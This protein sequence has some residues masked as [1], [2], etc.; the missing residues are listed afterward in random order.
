MSDT[1][2]VSIFDVLGWG[3]EKSGAQLVG[4]C[5]FCGKKKLYAN[6]LTSK[7]DCKACAE[8]G[9][10]VTA[11]SKMHELVW[12]PAFTDSVAEALGRFRG[13][14]VDAFQLSPLLGYDEDNS[15]YTW[16]VLKPNGMPTTVRHFKLPKAGKKSAVMALKGLPLGLLGAELLADDDRK[17]EP[18]YITEGEWDW[19][20]WQWALTVGD[21]PGIVVSLPGANVLS[22]D[23][24]GW[25]AGRDVIG[26]YDCD[27]AGRK[28]SVRAYEKL[29]ST[30]KTLKFLHWPR[31]DKQE[32]DGKRDGYDIHDL[33]KQY[34]DNPIVALDYVAS[35][36]KLTPTGQGE[37]PNA[38]VQSD[39]RRAA[40]EELEPI[41]VDELHKAFG[42]WLLLEN[43]DLV[44][45]TMAVLWTLHLPGNPLWMF[46]IAPPSGSKSETIMPA[47]AWWRV[48]A[49]SNMTSKSLVSGF[50]GP[51]GS[52]PSLLAALDGERACLAIKD[53]TPLL[54]GRPEERDEVFGILR[55]A[56]DGSV[57]KVF[58]NG[59][60]RDYKK[61]HFTVMAGVTPAIDAMS[62]I[63]MGERFLKFRADRDV[64]RADDI[65]RAIRAVQNCG[66]EEAMRTELRDACVRA[67]VRPFDEN[68]VPKPSPVFAERVAKL[69]YLVA[70]L[71]A[72]SPVDK[73]S[74]RQTMHPMIEAPPRLATQFVK[75]AQGLA[76]HYETDT[77]ED[78]RVLRLLNRVA[79][80][81]ADTIS[82]TVAHVLYCNA[83][84]R[85]QDVGEI[86]LALPRLNRDT[87]REVL[88]R[89]TRLGILEVK[90]DGTALVHRFRPAVQAL[91]VQTRLFHDLPTS[92]VHYRADL[93]TGSGVAP[94]RTGLR[95]RKVK[96]KV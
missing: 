71:R 92:D 82:A 22:K 29:R 51:G 80:H 73:F 46:L 55:D 64:D 62:N 15:R 61:L 8:Y 4:E 43:Y 21:K 14:P 39:D 10:G 63:A 9:N 49:L 47:S 91:L 34:A 26:L 13:I 12:R 67:L 68:N 19:H 96:R 70:H 87:V 18:I 36:L 52:D 93:P 74:D 17:R 33:V 53:L 85:G 32:E 83:G 95:V 20:A 1:E 31:A 86:T 38:L 72:V 42:K 27:D 56:Y 3:L 24:I 58:G 44:D 57:C 76:L 66:N 30:A 69:A 65:L 78:P 40:Q 59:I 16:Q 54:Q 5:P 41:G 45:I 79:L 23:W 88:A 28:G 77:L 2:Q 81:T 89:W 25:F 50:Q 35:R 7:W 84:I 6:P 37:D 60:K 90:R 11:I 48:H 94:P 75:L